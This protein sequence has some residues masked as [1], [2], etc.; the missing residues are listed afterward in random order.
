MIKIK[1]KLIYM[2]KNVKKYTFVLGM[3]AVLLF[4]T[5]FVFAQDQNTRLEDLK[6]AAQTRAQEAKQQVQQ[7]REQAQ[8]KAK[9]MREDSKQ[10]INKIKDQKKR[11]A[12]VRIADQLNHINQVW[13]DHFANV[14]D[15]LDATLQKI[16]S[17]TEKASAA[18]RD[19]STVN[20]A[21][22]NAENAIASARTAV[23]N[24]A[25]KTY[26]VDTTAITQATST[27]SEQNNL[28]SQ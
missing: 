28:V 4:S 10:K 19:V 14:L 12:A 9:Q 27:T 25:Q 15:K 24:Q 18:G 7:L 2:I 16:K 20:T 6:R 21:I 11:D 22:Q 1:I 23:A 17:R 5:A 26:T 3:S 8:D 13:T